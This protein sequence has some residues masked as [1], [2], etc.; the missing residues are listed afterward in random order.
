MMNQQ[1]ADGRFQTLAGVGFHGS[2]QGYPGFAILSVDH[3]RGRVLLFAIYKKNDHLAAALLRAMVWT[4]T[5]WMCQAGDLQVERRYDA[6]ACM[7]QLF[8]N[9][10]IR[11]FT[12]FDL[13]VKNGS[14]GAHFS[15]L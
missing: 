14:S 13:K 11:L 5:I 7:G 15:I 12:R 4:L 2:R 1:M 9:P 10:M 3:Q 8:P 6:Q